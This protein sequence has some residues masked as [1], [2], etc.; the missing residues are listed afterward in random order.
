MQEPSSNV[1]I[2]R[3]KFAQRGRKSVKRKRFEVD[4]D[5]GIASTSAKQTS[6]DLT[7]NEL[8][9]N[10][11]SGN[12]LD[13]FLNDLPEGD[14]KLE[15]TELKVF[16]DSYAE[17][18]STSSTSEPF[19]LAKG[20]ANQKTSKLERI[21]SEFETFPFEKS[22]MESTTSLP[23]DADLY[24]NERGIRVDFGK[25]ESNECLMPTRSWHAVGL[26]LPIMKVLQSRNF[27]EPT[28]IQAQSLPIIMRGHDLLGIAPTGSGKTLAFAIP[29]CRHVASNMRNYQSAGFE[30]PFAL[31]VV[32][33]RE[34]CIQ[35]QRELSSWAASFNLKTLSCYGG[36]DIVAQISALVN[37][38]CDIII[39][40]PGRLIDLLAANNGRVL[41]LNSVTFLVVDETDRMFDLGFGP[42]VRK[43]VECIRP[44]RQTVVY[45]ATLPSP[46]E[47]LVLRILRDPIKVLVSRESQKP[48]VYSIPAEVEQN[49]ILVQNENS[50][51]AALM[52]LLS[53]ADER[54]ASL[55]FVNTQ[56]Q[57]DTLALKLN[58]REFCCRALHGGMDQRDR[59]EV[60]SDFTSGRLS[61][62]VA[63][64]V[65]ARGLDVKHLKLVINYDPASH[66][67][68][69]VHRA[70]RTGRAGER[71]SCTSLLLPTQ[72]KEAYYL[73]TLF[74][75]N[76]DLG[77]LAAEYESDHLNE[78]K[79]EIPKFTGFG[80]HGLAM[81]D[82]KR[83]VKTAV[84]K[85]A[86]DDTEISSALQESG[87]FE[88]IVKQGGQNS[89]SA[90]FIV[91]ELPKE[92]RVAVTSAAKQSE[93]S[94]NCHVSLTLRGSFMTAP[95]LKVDAESKLHIFIEGH[96][97]EDV[98]KALSCLRAYANEKLRGRHCSG[99]YTSF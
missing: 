49:A 48:Q 33:T 22:V 59:D 6:I 20:N 15:S 92:V 69:Y 67:E 58:A 97:E 39:A 32:P 88:S 87:N 27:K 66:V 91:N 26:P 50:R 61:I 57:A 35:I 12:D 94:Q 84:E 3:L 83:E 14:A 1:S 51:Y 53:K 38:R 25:L 2:L 63:T 79:V 73:S 93:V 72:K 44:D 5:R 13:S 17:T 45:S 70:G 30:G 24:R 89:F 86:H 19:N 4:D 56:T 68:D 71:G 60:I 8:D 40:T 75:L 65:A 78:T 29:L 21:R 42:Q 74:T 98:V 80:G 96:K 18:K 76:E 10:P 82:H 90:R 37:H 62:L 16:S 64:S 81:L 43:I 85:G 52:S 7:K 23:L 11:S 99:K 41:S 46:L 54:T 9:I 47:R 55:V 34:L 28:P 95:K 36:S 77:Q 31:V